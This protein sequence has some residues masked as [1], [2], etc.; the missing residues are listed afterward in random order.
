LKY[1]FFPGNIFN[2]LKI[3]NTARHCWLTPVILDT[4]EAQRRRITIQSQPRLVFS[5]PYL[6][7]TQHKKRAGRMAQE[8]LPSKCEA[9]SSNANTEISKYCN[10]IGIPTS[11]EM[12][13]AT[14]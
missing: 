2:S 8:H 1:F 10:A 6:G 13:H 4:Q 12:L 5:R 9:L 14:F 3:N 11:S 7:N